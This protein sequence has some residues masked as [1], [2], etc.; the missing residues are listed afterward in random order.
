[1]NYPLLA[2]FLGQF[3]CAVGATMV[4]AALWAIY[5]REFT[6]FGAFLASGTIAAAGGGLLWFLGRHAD[7]ARMYQR[8]TLGLVGLTW[9]VAA[10]A[11]ALPY[12]FTGSLAPVDA[13]FESMSGF[14]TTGSSVYWAENPIEAQPKSLLFWRSFTH[15]LGGMGI[16]VLFIAVLPYLGAGGKQLF[17]SESPGPDPRSLRPRIQQ[18]AT[19]LYRIY[20]G[21]TLLQTVALMVAGMS[22]YDAL[23]HTFATLATGGFSTRNSS[24]AAFDSFAIEIIIIVFMIAAGSNFALFFGLLRGNLRSFYRDP[25]WRYYIGILALATV[26]ITLNLS[27]WGGDPPTANDVTPDR[28]PVQYS[29]AESARLAAFQTVSVMTTTGFATDDFHYWPNFSRMLLVVLMFVGG[30]AGSTAGGMK[31]VR[32]VLLAKLVARRLQ[33]TFRPKHVR[34]IRM[35]GEVID[36]ESL[37]NIAVFFVLFHVW[38]IGGTLFMSWLGLPFETALT[39]V[40]ATLNNIGPGL[41]LVSAF[42]DFHAIPDSGKLFLSLCMVLGRLELLTICVMFLPAFWRP[43]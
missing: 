36:E 35:G 29:V 9:I 24:I 3:A 22:F 8:E 37:S 30:C 25:E 31:V 42:G 26:L 17:K 18:S 20:F 10:A 39:A 23:C 34:S 32:I 21:L 15:W 4:P 41:E 16:I 5:F 43:R 33:T 2:R 7:T 6:A 27:G 1:M 13:F 14:T 38:M 12:V 19:I 28:E 11:G 40:A